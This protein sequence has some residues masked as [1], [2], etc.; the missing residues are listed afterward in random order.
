[1]DRRVFCRTLASLPFAAGALDRAWSQPTTARAGQ[2]LNVLFISVD[3]LNDWV[4]PLGG[5]PGVRTP[6]IARLAQQG[7]VFTRA[8]CSAP[9]C[10]SSRSSVLTGLR[11]GSTGVY[12][13]DQALAEHMPAAVTLPQC[14]KR[15]NYRVL[16]GGK[17]FHGGYPYADLAQAVSRPQRL[18][19]HDAD[20]NEKLWDERFIF[21]P[22]SMSSGYPLTGLQ[23][24]PLDWGP[25]TDREAET[26]DA[27]LAEWAG[28]QLG[29]RHA[30]PFFLAVGFYRPH[31]PWY[32]PRRYFNL[33]PLAAIQLPRI[34]ADDLADLPPIARSWV[35]D[36][37]DFRAI[38]S[39][40]LW[41]QAV[42]AYLASITYADHHI[43]RVL[44]AWR[45][46]PERDRTIVV[47][48]SDH[49]WHLGEKLHFRKFT[50]WE[51]ATRV[52][53]MIVAPGYP[54]AARIE[55]TTSLLDLYPTLAELCG[56]EAPP[57]LE[58]HSLVPLL[59]NHRTRWPWPAYSTWGAG[60]HA[61]RTERF[62][63]IR[64][65]DGSEELYDHR[66][67]P[68]EWYNRAAD[69]RYHTVLA[70]LRPLLEPLLKPEQA[71]PRRLRGFI[72]DHLK[73]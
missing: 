72:H 57:G 31:L 56:L 62:R 46:S 19:W 52:P 1:M 49:G 69:A 16:G 32:V 5:Y 45:Q 14:F 24:G 39:A 68:E 20:P 67:D 41:R 51:R 30:Q 37:H 40:G 38:Q 22:E 66:S 70:A 10:N 27:R 8:Y 23:K 33:Y 73:I 48:W 54:Q 26:P 44:Q 43:G 42:Q 15:H 25:A 13:A 64:Y 58:G 12:S 2:P 18:V 65:S 71:W 34:K 4:Q 36:R 60:N 47:L 61:L 6:H 63:Y 35:D 21:P 29:R 55:Q 11:P 59:Q 7:A 9:E 50:L 3:D 28:A 17:I 53:M